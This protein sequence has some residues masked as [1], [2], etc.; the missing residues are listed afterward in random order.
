M[1]DKKIL[2]TGH[3]G[4]IGTNLINLFPKNNYI[5]CKID[6]RD[7]KKVFSWIKKNNFDLFIHLA[8]VVPIKK[9]EK[10]LKNSF[11]VNFIGTKNI[12]D[13]FIKFKK[14]NFWFFYSSTSHV[15]GSNKSLIR[16]KETDKL[17]PLNYYAKTK[18]YSE[19]YILKKLKNKN[20]KF[21]IGRIFSFTDNNQDKSFFIPAMFQ[22]INDKKIKQFTFNGSDNLRDFIH[23]KEIVS[24]INLLYKNN[25]TG[26]FNICSGKSYSLKKIL[27]KIIKLCKSKK[28][29]IFLKTSKRDNIIGN[30]NKLYNQIK[31]KPKSNLD[32]VLKKYWKGHYNK[33]L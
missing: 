26:I 12:V 14:K 25:S 8:A 11:E 9:V 28:K 30:V 18:V 15:Y 31:K 3:T 13:A 32:E 22:K 27:F 24:S 29:I 10:N 20:V 5:K 1:K 16:F 2:I 23:I 4:V 7:K 17:K 6:I 21:C 33:E 19:N